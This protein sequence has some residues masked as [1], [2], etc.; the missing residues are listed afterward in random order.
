VLSRRTRALLLDAAESIRIAET[1]ARYMAELLKKDELWILQQLEQY[2]NLASQYLY[3]NKQ[4]G[5]VYELHK[6]L[7]AI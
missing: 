1:V 6:G 7:N 3:Q 4:T 2:K 5:A